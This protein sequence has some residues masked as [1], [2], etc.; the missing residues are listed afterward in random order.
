ME[1]AEAGGE[2]STSEVQELVVL[3]LMVEEACVVKLGV[4]SASPFFDFFLSFQCTLL[5]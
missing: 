2:T 5:P 3:V 4:N 1:G